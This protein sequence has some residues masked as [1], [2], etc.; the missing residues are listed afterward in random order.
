M[1]KAQSAPPAATAHS[2]GNG[3]QGKSTDTPLVNAPAWEV[4]VTGKNCLNDSRPQRTNEGT[5]I[6]LTPKHG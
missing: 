6:I 4:R 5:G 1:G 3:N 2:I